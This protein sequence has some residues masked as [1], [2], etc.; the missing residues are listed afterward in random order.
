MKPLTRK[1]MY[2][3]DALTGEVI[4]ILPHGPLPKKYAPR[5]KYDPATEDEKH[6]RQNEQHNNP[7]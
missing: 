3:K 5:S 1:D 7:R 4:C 2:K 6:R